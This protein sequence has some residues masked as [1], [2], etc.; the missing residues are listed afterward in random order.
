VMR[1][2][3]AARVVA[4]ASGCD[5]NSIAHLR[6]QLLLPCFLARTADAALGS[7]CAEIQAKRARSRVQ[8]I[9]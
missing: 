9:F 1:S 7:P 5:T 8:E 4:N 3:E 6:L 2:L